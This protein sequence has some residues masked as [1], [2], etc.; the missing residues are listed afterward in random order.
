MHRRRLHLEAMGGCWNRPSDP[1]HSDCLMSL[2]NLCLALRCRGWAR[3]EHLSLRTRCL[4]PVIATCLNNDAIVHCCATGN[5]PPGA[6]F[7]PF[8]HT[9]VLDAPGNFT[10][11][12][13]KSFPIA[14][15]GLSSL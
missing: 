10:S 14:L 7:S 9:D 1:A 11:A 6:R 12:A 2:W 13:G 15:C 8:D 5:V 4:V 3:P